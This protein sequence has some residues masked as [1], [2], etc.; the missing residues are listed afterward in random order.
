MVD[1]GKFRSLEGGGHIFLSLAHLAPKCL[2][3]DTS[4]YHKNEFPFKA[5]PLFHEK[6]KLLN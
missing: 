6:K 1:G 5:L 4:W 3:S 2:I